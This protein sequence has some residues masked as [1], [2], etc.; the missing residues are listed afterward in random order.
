MPRV[1]IRPGAPFEDAGDWPKKAIYPT[2]DELSAELGQELLPFI[3]LLSPAD[4][5]G[6]VRRW[7]PRAGGPMMHY[8]YAFQWFAMA[9]AVLGFLFW[10]MRTGR[11]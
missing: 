10:R 4:D 11:R 5:D 9:T 6:Y 3:V 1:G 2:L 8:G 7:Q